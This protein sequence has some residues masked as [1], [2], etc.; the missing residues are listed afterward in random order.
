MGPG[1]RDLSRLVD[2]GLREN[3]RAFGQKP[4][5]ETSATPAPA[6]GEAP[7]PM[8]SMADVSWDDHAQPDDSDYSVPLAG[9]PQP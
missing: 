4:G 8:A 9:I 5:A 3:C 1:R 6:T 2:A 7:V